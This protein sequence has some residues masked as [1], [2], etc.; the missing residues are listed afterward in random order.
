MIHLNSTVGEV[1]G[2]AVAEFG[3]GDISL[4]IGGKTNDRLVYV[5]LSNQEAREVGK[6]EQH[7][8]TN[9]NDIKPQMMFIFSNPNSIDVVISRLQEAKEC[10]INLQSGKL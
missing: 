2:I 7:N 3:A 5:M 6:V 9:V 8:Y 1:K 4:I 10:L